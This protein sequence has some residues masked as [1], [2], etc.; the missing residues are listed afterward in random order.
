MKLST[1]AL[2]TSLFTSINLFAI[3][4]QDRWEMIRASTDVYIQQPSFAQVFG[5][6]GLFN[7]CHTPKEFKSL[8]PVKNCITYRNVIHHTSE[9]AFND[10]VCTKYEKKF[11][12][13]SRFYLK[14]GS[15]HAIYPETIKLIVFEAQDSE[16]AAFLFAK[17]YTL[18]PCE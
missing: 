2:I 3:T 4:G 12:S 10:Y 15:T 1:I 18:P 5:Q 17:N 11:A 13:V 7:A 16:A 14:N 6:H 9:G 8:T